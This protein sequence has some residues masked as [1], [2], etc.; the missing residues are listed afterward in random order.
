MAEVMGSPSAAGSRSRPRMCCRFQCRFPTAACRAEPRLLPPSTECS[1]AA[2]TS[3]T[4]A[5]T[6]RCWGSHWLLPFFPGTLSTRT[7]RAVALSGP[8][9]QASPDDSRRGPG[10]AV[11][12]LLRTD[13][14]LRE[15]FL[16]RLPGL[17]AAVVRGGVPSLCC[18]LPAG[19]GPGGGGGKP[20]RGERSRL[21]GDRYARSRYVAYG[22]RW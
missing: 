21:G 19:G 3:G 1:I 17:M 5:G 13:C 16:P 15:A 14:P 11:S 20:P 9:P 12:R 4:R 2:G 22:W 6:G 8:A 10:A 18:R 7:A